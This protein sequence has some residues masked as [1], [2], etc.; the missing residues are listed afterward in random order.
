MLDFAVSFGAS[1][2]VSSGP[3]ARSDPVDQRLAILKWTT[4]VIDYAFLVAFLAVAEAWMGGENFT[5]I[6]YAMVPL[7][8]SILSISVEYFKA[9]ALAPESLSKEKLAHLRSVARE[10]QSYLGHPGA[11]GAFLG[12]VMQGEGIFWDFANNDETRKG[13]LFHVFY[14]LKSTAYF[15]TILYVE[16]SLGLVHWRLCWATPRCS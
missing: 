10:L 16:T 15:A 9:F 4:R 14:L 7:V 3:W 2:L 12:R 5:P 11:V 6:R 13:A 1:C 8:L